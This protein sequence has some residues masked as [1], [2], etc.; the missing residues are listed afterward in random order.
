MKK[1]ESEIISLIGEY[2][3]G[4]MEESR[5]KELICWLEEKKEN[6]QFFNKICTNY[7]FSYRWNLRNQINTETAIR[8]FDQ[9]TGY[10]FPFFLKKRV[11]VYA[12]VAAVILVL[13]CMLPLYFRPNHPSGE[14]AEQGTILPGS[15]QAILILAN[16]EKIQLQGKDS[17]VFQVG[18]G[19]VLT[20]KGDQLIYKGKLP[21]EVQF[22]ELHVPRGGEYTLCLSDGTVVQLNSGSSL[23]YPVAFGK[24][25]REV[26]LSGEA[27]FNVQ[28]NKVSFVVKVGNLET[29]VYGTAFN[30]NTHLENKIQIALAEGQVG[31][32]MKGESREV[33][34]KPSQLADFDIGTRKLEIRETNL[35]PYL[36]WTKGLFVFRNETLH[37]IM[38]TLSLWYDME[39]IY[40]NPALREFHFTGCVK[41]YDD[42]NVIL[43][44]LS[45][46]VG[47]K[48]KQRDRTLTISY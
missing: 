6:Q 38:S 10:R 21:D 46:S 42:I 18:E 28:K 9:R 39:V 25:K 4:E 26:R 22:N 14:R 37:Q 3:T 35:E 40:E 11:F 33:L 30:I 7:S 45:K 16:G 15:P 23:K 27:F 17:L 32:R 43:K 2:L 19:T 8:N 36:G 48:F 34:L 20:N 31:I 24:E 5:R 47:V 12:G 1:N 13:F 41:R 44:A 29:R